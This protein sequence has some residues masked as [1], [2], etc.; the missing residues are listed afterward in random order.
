MN[1]R[2]RFER[3]RMLVISSWPD[4]EVKRAALA[5]AAAAFEREMQFAQSP[6]R[7]PSLIPEA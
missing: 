1:E 4:S 6:P 2:L 5:S 3:Y 7:S